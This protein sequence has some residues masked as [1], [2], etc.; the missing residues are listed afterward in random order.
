MSLK[1]YLDR[2]IDTYPVADHLSRD[3]V[4]AVHRYDDP[5]DREVAGFVASALAYG[6]VRAVLASVDSVLETM[7]PH[8]A[9]FVAGFDPTRDGARFRGFVHRWNNA[10]DLSVLMWILGRIR[11]GHGTIESAVASG[12]FPGEAAVAGGL[13]RFSEMALGFGHE[14]FYSRRDLRTRRGVRYFFPRPSDGSA[15]KRLNLY[16]RWM[17]RPDDGIDCGVWTAIRPSELVIPIDTHLARISRYIGLTR[18]AS[19]GW[20][21][22]EDVTASLRQL[23][24]ADPVRYDFALCH[25]GIAGDCP[26]KRDLVK[27]VRCPIQPV[28][29]L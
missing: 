12:I 14:Q 16:L 10:R 18:Y 20:K 19:P 29:L 26:K 4:R 24:P 23:D 5:D 3:P 13:D 28:C 9:A 27:C 1:H 8:P 17:V 22:A 6:N 11:E 15:C 25:L 7:G 21:M 2:F